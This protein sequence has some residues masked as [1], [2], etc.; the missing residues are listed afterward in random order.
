M[1]DA[2]KANF[3]QASS[4]D[5]PAF[6]ALDLIQFGL[7]HE[8]PTA[9]RLGELALAEAQADPSVPTMPRSLAQAVKDFMM[10]HS[11]EYNAAAEQTGP[12]NVSQIYHKANQ[13]GKDR[14]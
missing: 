7:K 6:Y 2:L 9:V 10:K 5:F 1:E 4:P 11:D 3:T 8:N 14:D 12:I 13:Q